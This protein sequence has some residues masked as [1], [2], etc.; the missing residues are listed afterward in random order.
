MS[1]I[2]ELIEELCPNGIP[3][4]T[5]NEIGTFVRGAG[6]L[7]AELSQSGFP[8]IHY[9]EI[10]TKYILSATTLFS[11]IA[12]PKRNY[13]Q[14][15]PNDLIIVTTSEDAAGVGKPLAWLGTET[16]YVSGETYIFKHSQNAKFLAYLL[17]SDDFQ[18]K[19]LPFITGTKV[20]RIHEKAFLRIQFPIPPIKIQNEIVSFLDKF[21][22]LEAELEAE[23]EVRKAQYEFNRNLL[24][25]FNEGEVPSY[26]LG[27][28]GQTISGL[29]GKSKSDFTDGNAPYV[30]YVDI[31]NNPELNF[32]VQKLVKVGKSESQNEIR[33]GDVL[34]TGS[35]ETKIDVGLTSV[36]TIE[37]K[38]KT[39]I[40]SFCFIWRPHK[41]I[42]ILPEFSKHLFRGRE[43]RD[44]VI[45]T[46][47][48]VTRMNISKPKLLAIKIPVP[49]LK[50]Q[51]ESVEILNNFDTLANDISVGIP[52]EINARRLQYEY[53]RNKLL[54]FRELE[55]V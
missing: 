24:L 2:G 29:R 27:E 50:I 18:I 55:K 49:P 22:E 30:S 32:E 10:H 37:P 7:K 9:G 21:A 11:F 23:R 36:V 48:G 4:K 15:D 34:I 8:V 19:K 5:L 44:K 12:E 17:D 40:N 45:E 25:S 41:E 33:L 39:Y 54:S 53:Y 47:N 43:F 28:I 46:A 16:P 14:V 6:I 20:K 38:I 31:S 51:R 42:E 52:A 26:S 1:K 13:K 35:S 3:F